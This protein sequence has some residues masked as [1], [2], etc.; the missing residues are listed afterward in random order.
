MVLEGLDL[1]SNNGTGHDWA[2]IKAAGKSFAICKRS[3]GIGYIDP[4]LEDNW[5]GA[6]GVFMV[7]GGYHFAHPGVNS[8]DAEAGY[9]LSH[10]PALQPGDLL[11]LDI[12]VEGGPN[13]AAW[14]I[15]FGRAVLAA[16]GFPPLLYTFAAYAQEWLHDPGLAFMPLWLADWA[17]SI[18][19]GI[20]PWASIALWQYSG[21]GSCPGVS[22]EVDLSRISRDLAG[23]KALGKPAPK[24]PVTRVAVPKAD[25]KPSP[26]H[27]SHSLGTVHKG[28][29]LTFT[30]QT[31]P[32]WAQVKML[33]GMC[34]DK[35]GWLLRADLQ[36]V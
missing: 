13:V 27:V 2:A 3:E 17:P 21:H 12:E 29:T 26:D 30:G 7:P 5:A 35:T 8:A 33:I 18:P 10:L 1:S 20:G 19:A 9:F 11:A 32:H 15:R 4:T 16:S 31:T 34:K 6:R 25:L 14:A 28:D 23:L 36:T 22:G 24:P